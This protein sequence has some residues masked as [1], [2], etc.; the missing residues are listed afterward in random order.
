MKKAFLILFILGF[1]IGSAQA[2]TILTNLNDLRREYLTDNK[3]QIHFK[4]LNNLS[5]DGIVAIHGTS[6][7]S[8]KRYTIDERAEMYRH[9]NT[10]FVLVEDLAY[11]VAVYRDAH[12]L[13]GHVDSWMLYNEPWM[14]VP[15]IVEYMVCDV[16][17]DQMWEAHK[18]ILSP[19]QIT[20][21]INSLYDRYEKQYSDVTVL[22]RSYH[23]KDKQLTDIAMADPRVDGVL[24]ELAFGVTLGKDSKDIADLIIAGQKAGKRVFLFNNSVKGLNQPSVMMQLIKYLRNHLTSKQLAN[25]NLFIIPSN[26][27]TFPGKPGKPD[28]RWFGEGNT[29][30]ATIKVLKSQPE[31]VNYIGNQDYHEGSK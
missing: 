8:M 18:T 2:F 16:P 13:L 10:D 12:K 29:V 27:G 9:L 21:A 6:D 3:G 26:Y 1:S 11:T 5:S 23:G 19:D 15:P 25:P 7:N 17:P 31:W 24:M 22:T 28:C 4:W 14:Y 20:S 30:E